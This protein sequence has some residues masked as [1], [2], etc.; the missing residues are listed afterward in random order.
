MF[1]IL[2]VGGVGGVVCVNIMSILLTDLEEVS[3]IFPGQ[4]SCS[5]HGKQLRSQYYTHHCL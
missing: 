1:G 5:K 4:W 2:V 3:C